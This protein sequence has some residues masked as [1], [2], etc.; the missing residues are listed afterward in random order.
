MGRDGEPAGQPNRSMRGFWLIAAG[1]LAATAAA[2][3]QPAF[4]R[5]LGPVPPVVAVAA[6]AGIGWVSLRAL[7]RRGWLPGSADRP[8]DTGRHRKR[9]ANRL[10]L[11]A[12]AAVP[13]A[14]AAIAFDTWGVAF[15]VDTNVAWPDSLIFYPA[16]G[17]VAGVVFRAAPLA[18]LVA[19]AR[20]DL[21]AET[22]GELRRDDWR[23]HPGAAIVAVAS[24]EAVYQTVGSPSGFEPARALFVAPHLFAFGVVELTILRRCGFE[25]MYTFRLCYYL[26]WH[27]GWGAARLEL[28]F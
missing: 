6:A 20:W 12:A 24:L 8:N 23:R 3:D 18:A 11:A 26:I 14:G 17:F 1:S 16:I 27:V 2:A 19:L 25:T 22:A 4:G 13:L 21:G 10:G 9:L 5:F 15:P 7:A 28:L